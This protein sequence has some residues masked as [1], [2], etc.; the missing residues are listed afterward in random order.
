MVTY[1]FVLSIAGTLI[2]I[3]FTIIGFFIVRY[4]KGQDA[5]NRELREALKQLNEIMT[6]LLQKEAINKEE[7][8]AL[9]QAC[10]IRHKEAI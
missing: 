1:V 7:I 8:L 10:K 6:D 2:L 4:F 5:V 3:L 9:G